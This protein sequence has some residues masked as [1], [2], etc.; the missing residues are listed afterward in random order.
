MLT[1]LVT[2][3]ERLENVARQSQYAKKL[4]K[5]VK[6]DQTLLLKEMLD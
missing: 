4:L 5:L 1:T 3:P 2:V 6:W